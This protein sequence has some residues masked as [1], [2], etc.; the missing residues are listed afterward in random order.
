MNFRMRHGICL[1]FKSQL[2][3]HSM[4][5]NEKQV[6]FYLIKLRSLSVTR[7]QINKKKIEKK[8]KTSKR[9]KKKNTQTPVTLTK[10][11]YKEI[12]ENQQQIKCGCLFGTIVTEMAD[13]F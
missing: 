1:F 7:Q 10:F 12:Y 4:N 8:K 6:K 2:Y 3:T 9:Q 11:K 5:R 13:E